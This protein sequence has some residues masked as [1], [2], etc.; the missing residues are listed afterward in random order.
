VVVGHSFP[1]APIPSVTTQKG[2]RFES[3]EQAQAYLDGWEAS[4]AG[5]Y[6]TTK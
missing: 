2:L 5:I 3:L 1:L 6:G 4:W